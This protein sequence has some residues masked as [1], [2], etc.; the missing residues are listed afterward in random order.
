MD[1]ADKRFIAKFA[2]DTA[3]MTMAEKRNM[4]LDDIRAMMEKSDNELL[5]KRE[6]KQMEIDSSEREMA[7]EAAVTQQQPTEKATGGGNF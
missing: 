2:R 6:I 3:M 4:N 7:V 5:A 1:S